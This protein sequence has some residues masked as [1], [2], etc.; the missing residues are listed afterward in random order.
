[1]V[2]KAFETAIATCEAAISPTFQPDAFQPAAQQVGNLLQ[3][4]GR[5]E[6]AVIWHTQAQAQAPDME[7]VYN[8]LGRVYIVQERWDDA[9][10]A[11]QAILAQ[12]AEM[13]EAYW[14]LAS[15]HYIQNRRKQALHYWARALSFEPHKA[16]P[17]G[18]V[19]FGNSF[20]KLG[21][22]KEA[23]NCYRRAIYIDK[24]YVPAYRQ[25]AQAFLKQGRRDDAVAIYK[26][27]I[28]RVEQPGV[29]YYDLGH[30]FKDQDQT[31]Q[32]MAIFQ[33]AI[34]HD[35]D[36]PW[37]HHD[38]VQFLL[39]EER[40]EE[41][42][43]ASIAT[44]SR[45]PTL[46]WAYTQM[47]RALIATGKRDEAINAHQKACVLRGWT[48]CETKGY[49]FSQD[50]FSHNIPIWLDYLKGFIGRPSL[51]ACEVGSFQGMSAC[52]ILDHLLTHPTAQ[53]TCIE[54]NF[55]PEFDR[56]IARTGTAQKVD[57]REGISDQ[58]FP[59]LPNRSFDLVY[60]D[61][62]H[63]ADFVKR[64]G[65]RAWRKL[66]PGGILIFDDYAWTDP[67]YPDQDPKLGIDAVLKEIQGN[68]TVL[69]H[70]YQIIV[71]KKLVPKN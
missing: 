26:E 3:S 51:K 50:W 59:C 11:Y 7:Q 23:L 21:K 54:P 20:L 36:Y 71:Q 17:D 42:I 34:N 5:F 12:N 48:D 41:A 46:P 10:S 29:L 53:M 24:N 58:V 57:K 70:A 27:A 4:M 8:G 28:K 61:G 40:W 2:N 66:K 65:L 39:A 52:W 6:D 18:H 62:C 44:I 30:I 60:V 32:A 1:M 16:T 47:G 45:D 19:R 31:G 69:H 67:E 22:I 13:V 9:I 15:I 55:Q 35:P 38:W 33:E 37:N 43:A 64:D 49:E 25:L 63:L 68:A 14:K 56:N